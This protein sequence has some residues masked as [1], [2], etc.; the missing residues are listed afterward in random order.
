MGIATKNL[1]DENTIREMAGQARP[2]VAVTKI[3]ELT[4]G[5]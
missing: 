1:Q 5:E 4:E 2:G 3:K